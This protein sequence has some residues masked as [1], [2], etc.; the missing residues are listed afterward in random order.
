MASDR[1]NN[2]E[3]TTPDQGEYPEDIT[4]SSTTDELLFFS[5]SPL[6]FTSEIMPSNDESN[7]NIVQES[8]STTVE[9][10]TE[11][12]QSLAS[13]DD[14]QVEAKTDLPHDDI[15]TEVNFKGFIL[16]LIHHISFSIL[17]FSC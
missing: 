4:I 12:D 13:T 7:E 3:L 16:L 14:A 2:D 11:P 1:S 5:S 17:A 6:T 9:L 8:S 15:E 10:T